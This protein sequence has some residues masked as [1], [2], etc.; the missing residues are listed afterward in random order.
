M[1]TL[2]TANLSVQTMMTTE[3]DISQNGSTAVMVLWRLM[4]H[5]TVSQ[6]LSHRL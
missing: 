5:K 6:H 2:D 4:F 1:N 3:M